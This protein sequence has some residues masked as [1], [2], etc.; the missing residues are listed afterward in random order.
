MLPAAAAVP[1]TG[2]APRAPSSSL[3]IVSRIM[4]ASG[5]VPL[6]ED[7]VKGLLPVS[8]SWPWVCPPDMVVDPLR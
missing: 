2:A 4:G 7:P 5:L 8:E 6:G 3:D 1:A